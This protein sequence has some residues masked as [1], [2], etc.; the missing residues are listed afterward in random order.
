MFAVTYNY[1]WHPG[2]GDP[3]F[4]G[5]F[6][7][8]SYFLAAV[9][10]CR[11]AYKER[12]QAR[13]DSSRSLVLWGGLAALLVLLGINKQL[14]LQTWLTFAVRRIAIDQ[15]WYERR[16]Q[17][18]ALF[19]VFVALFGVAGLGFLWWLGWGL[20]NRLA[21]VGGTFLTS[22]VLVRASSFH[23]VDQ[24]LGFELG[25]L[26]MNWVLELGGI[27]CIAWAA[28]RKPPREAHLPGTAPVRSETA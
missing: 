5:W 11:A 15:G 9:L 20:G 18:Q 13:N 24:L 7:V 25:G 8:F 23:H 14:D 3:T 16:R 12:M 21:I 28:W 19:F 1:E 22:F 6:T 2:I 17:A 4:M 26:K 27:W 10:C